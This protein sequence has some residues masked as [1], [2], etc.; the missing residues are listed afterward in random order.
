V[1]FADENLEAA[2]REELE[3]PEEPLTKG[4]IRKLISLDTV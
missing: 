1:V 2:V 4:T 3:K